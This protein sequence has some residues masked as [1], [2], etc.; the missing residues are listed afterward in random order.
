MITFSV[1]SVIEGTYAGQA[2]YVRVFIDSF[3]RNASG[4][5]IG[6]NYKWQQFTPAQ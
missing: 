5:V 3:N 4:D 1:P 2:Y 6:V